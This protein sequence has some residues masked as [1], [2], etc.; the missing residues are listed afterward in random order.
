MCVRP[1]KRRKRTIN[2]HVSVP[3]RPPVVH[4]QSSCNNI[5]PPPPPPP[6]PIPSSPISESPHLHSSSTYHTAPTCSSPTIS[7]PPSSPRHQNER[8]LPEHAGNALN[9][10]ATIN[11][12]GFYAQDMPLAPVITNKYALQED[13]PMDGQFKTKE[14]AIYPPPA[15]FTI[16]NSD[17]CDRFQYANHQSYRSNDRYEIFIVKINLLIYFKM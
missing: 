5:R 12:S 9:Q 17:R 3:Y 13:L 10:S 15:V 1:K 11:M 4:Q 7:S 14:N 16:L 2:R 8:L 6:P